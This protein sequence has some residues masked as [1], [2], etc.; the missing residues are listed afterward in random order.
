[1]KKK[2][3]IETFGCQMNKSDSELMALSM[4]KHGFELT[5]NL[6]DASIVV[7]NT[8][9][10][11]QNAEDRVLARIQSSKD[12]IKKNKG[13]III[14]GCMAQR[15]GE[16]LTS[17]KIADLIIGPYQSP[18]I[19]DIINIF[20][21]NK[22]KKLYTSQDVKDFSY[23]LDNSLADNVEQKW[24]EWVTI[25]HGCENYCSYCIV[26]YVRGKLI[27]FNSDTILEYIKILAAKGVKEITLLGQNVNQYG[28]DNNDIPFYQ[29]LDKTAKIKEIEKIN[30]LTS[31]PK[32][33]S[34]DIIKVIGSHENISKSIHLPLQS[35][36]DNI[37]KLMNRKY[38][39]DHYYRIVEKMDSILHVYSITTD[40]IVG[41]P[42][43][44]EKNFEETL[45]AVREIKFDDAFTYAYS[46]REGT[47][48]YKLNE[49]LARN[50]KISRLNKLIEIQRAI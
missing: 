6:D 1:M 34:E 40:L 42:G 25:T 16:Q 11:R 7:F 8:C 13:I 39:Y 38:N 47:P 31:H 26:P 30:Y 46:A 36:S 5:D 35:G 17:D 20:L 29:L 41:F 50:E 27:S 49:E 3:L 15:I 43:E 9:S 28:T 44:T 14:T 23:R 21:N 10:V 4:D 19:G 22:N 33:F 32:D 45:D 48:A 24:H 2:Y 18:K 37:L 12:R